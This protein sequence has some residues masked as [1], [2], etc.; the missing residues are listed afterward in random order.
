[1]TKG[2]KGESRA[3]AKAREIR[4]RCGHVE[5]LNVFNE[6]VIPQSNTQK[7]EVETGRRQTG[8]EVVIGSLTRLLLSAP[9]RAGYALC[10]P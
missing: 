9:Q 7:V 8:S 4:H 3:A 6:P 5:R 2:N 1:M 10:S